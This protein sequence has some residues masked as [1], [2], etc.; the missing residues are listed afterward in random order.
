MPESLHSNPET[1]QIN[2]FSALFDVAKQKFIDDAEGCTYIP[3]FMFVEVSSDA[4]TRSHTELVTIVPELGEDKADAPTKGSFSYGQVALSALS[5]ETRFAVNSL[6]SDFSIIGPRRV[7]D[8]QLPGLLYKSKP[9]YPPNLLREFAKISR[10]QES[11][12]QVLDVALSE[13]YETANS[14]YIQLLQTVGNQSDYKTQLG[15]TSNIFGKTLL[16]KF[17]FANNGVNLT[18]TSRDIQTKLLETSD[19]DE[20]KRLLHSIEKD[21]TKQ[22]SALSIGH[23]KFKLT[24]NFLAPFEERGLLLPDTEGS[25]LN[26]PRILTN[27]KF[28]ELKIKRLKSPD[29]NTPKLS[30]KDSI[31]MAKMF[32]KQLFDVLEQDPSRHAQNIGV[33]KQKVFPNQRTP[34]GLSLTHLVAFSNKITEGLNANKPESYQRR[35]LQP[36]RQGAATEALKRILL[37]TSTR[38]IPAKREAE[39]RQEDKLYL[40]LFGLLLE[41]PADKTTTKQ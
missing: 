18:Q 28:A 6:T 39:H 41:R 20:A 13:E 38:S 11:L 3:G 26:N 2:G 23:S 10:K 30:E 9:A 34:D 29:L 31:V 27:K 12:L 40:E 1:D 19:R 8:Q 21:M 37:M 17:L 24:A 14:H 33:I 32:V 16:S 22:L 25:I 36:N 4:T 5:S 7:I 15:I 35:L